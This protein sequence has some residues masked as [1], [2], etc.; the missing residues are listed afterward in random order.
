LNPQGL[1]RPV[2]ELFYKLVNAEI[3]NL[4]T[5]ISTFQCLLCRVNEKNT[6]L[7][8]KTGSSGAKELLAVLE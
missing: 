6:S 4:K 2:Q 8:H 1:S 7:R 3:S 5:E